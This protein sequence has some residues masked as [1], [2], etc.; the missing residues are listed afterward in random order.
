MMVWVI[1]FSVRQNLWCGLRRSVLGQD[2]SETKKS[3]LVLVLVLK[4][5][6]CIVKH[7]L[8]TS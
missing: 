4:V 8:V 7:D 2:W 1:E 6:Y 5:W 3:V